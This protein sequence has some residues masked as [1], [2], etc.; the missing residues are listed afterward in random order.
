MS[1]RLQTLPVTDEEKLRYFAKRARECMAH[2]LRVYP[3]DDKRDTIVS[4]LS[5]LAG[6]AE[7]SADGKSDENSIQRIAKVFIVTDDVFGADG[8]HVIEYGGT[9]YTLE[10]PL[11]ISTSDC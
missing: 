3:Q 11:G 1:F 9:A 10:Y 4:L 5:I 2:A 6:F 7:L 8:S